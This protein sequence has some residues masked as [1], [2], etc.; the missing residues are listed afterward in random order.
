MSAD[1]VRARPTSPA[2]LAPPPPAATQR[3]R[4]R[5]VLLALGVLAIA[6]IAVYLV[7]NVRAGWAFVLPFRGRRVAAMVLVGVAIATSTVAFQTLTANRILTPSIMGFDALY[8]A[9]QTALIFGLGSI[10]VVRIGQIAEFGLSAALMVGASLA[11]FGSLF[12]SGRRSV[13]LV[14]LIGVVLG[15]GLRS[16]TALL[17]RLMEP[18]EFQVLVSRLFASFTAVDETLLALAAVVVSGCCAALWSIRRRLDVLALGRQMAVS[19]G[20]DHRRTTML[21]LTLVTVLVSTSTALVGPITFFGL[22]VANLAYA[23]AGTHRHAVTLPT[24]AL[25]A[26]VTLVG[27]QAVL[28]HLLGAATVLSVVI[29]FLGGIVFIGM[30]VA[31]GRRR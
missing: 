17:Q 18:S 22:L 21:V 27:G 26:V 31:S 14:L 23:L 5:L 11:L 20:V 13:H 16:V 1:L 6:V 7:V 15:T 8:Q 29:E 30:L 10:A 25:L 24:A 3:R 12:S 9:L 19:L 2:P 4:E 28:E